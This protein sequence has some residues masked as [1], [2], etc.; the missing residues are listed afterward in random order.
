VSGSLDDRTT[1]FADHLHEHFVHPARVV[2]G[3][4]VVPH[5]PGYSIDMHPESYAALA[6]P[7]GSE[8]Q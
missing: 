1:E 7:G 2:D 4:Y 3:R 5:A 6:Y 8:W